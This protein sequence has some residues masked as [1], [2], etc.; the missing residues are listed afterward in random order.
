MIPATEMAQV[1]ELAQTI[2]KHYA[3]S[4]HNLQVPEI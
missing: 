4:R 3:G 1:I 2:Y